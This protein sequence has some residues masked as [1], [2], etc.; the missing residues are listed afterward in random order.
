MSFK[1]KHYINKNK[2][3]E[4]I[5]IFNKNSFAKIILNQGAS[6]DVLLLNNSI[7][8]KNLSPLSY[9]ETYA[10]AILFPFASRI[11]DGKYSYKNKQY[12]LSINE[13]QRNNAI[14]G[15][16]YNKVFTIEEEILNKNSAKL[17]LT[18]DETKSSLGFPYLYKVKLEYILTEDNLSLTAHFTN[19]SNSTFPFTYGWHPYFYSENLLKSTLQF[20]P[21][22]KIVFNEQMISKEFKNI[23]NEKKITIN[24]KVLDDC[25]KLKDP[26]ILFSTPKYQLE[27]NTTSRDNYL[28][29]YTPSNTNSVAIEPVSGVSDSFNN[30]ISLKELKPGGS[31]S[32]K[33]NLHV[34]THL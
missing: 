2:E 12:Q 19:T 17:V 27:I 16:L 15:L 4:V 6:L 1:S 13:P 33:W 8:I 10:S 26:K 11:K 25:Y 32:V 34:I 3:I 20:K 23:Q 7:I 14:H 24:N 29:I 30:K 28:Q 22:Q 21:T 31:Y 9:K 5:E 18:Y